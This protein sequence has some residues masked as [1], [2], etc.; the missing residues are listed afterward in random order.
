MVDEQQDGKSA[1]LI[2]F[3]WKIRLQGTE[4]RQTTQ[5]IN[6]NSQ[7]QKQNLLIL[8]MKKSSENSNP[9]VFLLDATEVLFTVHKKLSSNMDDVL[10]KYFLNK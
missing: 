2:P 3:H 4:L 8:K 6:D 9:I 5:K 10:T 7:N 1:M